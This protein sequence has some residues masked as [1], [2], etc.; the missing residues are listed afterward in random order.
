MDKDTCTGFWLLVDCGWNTALCA[1]AVVVR[2]GD[3]F[4]IPPRLVHRNSNADKDQ[5]LV[6]VNILVGRGDPVI[7][8]EGPRATSMRR[9]KEGNGKRGRRGDSKIFSVAQV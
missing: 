4:H 6:I 3:F 1:H 8:V 9:S 5:E 2:R 7:N